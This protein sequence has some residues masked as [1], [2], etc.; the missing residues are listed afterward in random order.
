[1]GLL[2]GD[3]ILLAG[4][5]GR[6]G[7]ATLTTLVREGARVI[8]ISRSL[9]RAASAIAVNAPNAGDRAIP[10]QADATDPAQAAA[11]VALCVERFGR[12]DALASLAGQ[13]PR[14]G[15]IVDSK[16]DDLHANITAYVDTAYNLSTAALRAMLTQPFR[17]G[18]TS[19]GRITTVSAGSSR[20]PA[21]RRGLFGVA[22]AAVNILMRAIAREHKA[23]GIVANAVVLGGVQVEESR[24]RR[25]A[26]GYAAAAT[27]QE[28]AETIA[29][30]C[31]AR[32]SGING[33]LVDLNA[34]ET[35]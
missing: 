6:V 27:P 28:V 31:S 19:R 10:F 29:F 34:R 3:A 30:L 16:L 1:M 4:A 5:T 23:D 15:P 7:G 11:A 14:L 32:G 20:D 25:G 22:K 33:E 21:P 12:I 9:E 18:A 13:Q 24:S 26:E 2:D 8:V 35:D 17:D